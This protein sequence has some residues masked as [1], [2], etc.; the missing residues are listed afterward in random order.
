MLGWVGSGRNV[1]VNTDGGPGSQVSIA[2]HLP[3]PAK[4]GEILGVIRGGS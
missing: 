4:V 3:S 2:T 1:V